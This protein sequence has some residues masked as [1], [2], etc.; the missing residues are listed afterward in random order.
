MTPTVLITGAGGFVGSHILEAVLLKTPWHIISVDSF[1]HNGRTEKFHSV[2]PRV[3]S[4]GRNI[5]LVTHD[6]NAPFSPAVIK[7]LQHT[8]YIINVASRCSVSESIDEPV[9]FIE[10][11]VKLMLN[12]LELARRVSLKGFVHFSTD[13]VYGADTPLTP[14][15]HRPS[16]P[17]AASKAAQEDICYAYRNTF[18]LPITVVNSA[19]M[20]GERQSTLAFIP[21]VVRA[22]LKGERIKLHAR[23]GKFGVRNYS[24]VRNVADH[25]V[26]EVFAENFD[27]RIHL[28]GQQ[29]LNNL[30]LAEMIADRVGRPLNYEVVEVEN[31][32]PGYDH[33]YAQ[34]SNPDWKPKVAFLDGLDKT[35]DWFKRNQDWFDE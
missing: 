33:K 2:I 25:V 15:D 8:N 21:K 24:Y 32:R 29:N 4:M 14:E 5:Q 31:E 34:M 28:P 22:A 19:N 16:S 9:E 1:R 23:R 11:N 20:F 26:Q 13:E 6:L 35:V 17:Y 18:K 30:T 7:K 3:H 27:S 10:N 12:V